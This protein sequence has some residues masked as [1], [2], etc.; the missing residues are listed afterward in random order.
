[1]TADNEHWKPIPD[2]PGY[3]VSDHGRVRSYYTPKNTGIWHTATTPQKIL[4][5]RIKTNGYHTVII[6]DTQ[7]KQL[8]KT[9]ASLV[10]LTFV[11]PRPDGMDVCHNNDDPSNNR[12]D[13]LRYDTRQNNIL[14][15]PAEKRRQMVKVDRRFLNDHMVTAILKRLSKG[16]CAAELAREYGISEATVSRWKNGNRRAHLLETSGVQLT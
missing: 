12:L 2:C 4:K 5:P 9:I 14:D 16:E 11:G 7:G 1:M 3:E 6:R 8:D 15:I 10:L 13:N